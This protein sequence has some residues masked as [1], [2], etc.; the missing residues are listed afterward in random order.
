LVGFGRG[1]EG[2]GRG[3]V[4]GARG[5]LFVWGGD[6][7]VGV[8][9]EGRDGDGS[10]GEVFELSARDAELLAE[11][12]GGEGA[13][14]EVGGSASQLVGARAADADDGS[15]LLDREEVGLGQIGGRRHIH[16]MP[17][18]DVLVAKNLC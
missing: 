8:V 12:D 10:T 7:R 1:V 15:G 18:K 3:W 4:I 6:V 16:D 2:G 14:A 13:F 9:G 5:V 11:A 17:L